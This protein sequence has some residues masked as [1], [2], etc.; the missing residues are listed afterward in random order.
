M[1]HSNSTN[2]VATA[3]MATPPRAVR[4]T[5]DQN[6]DDWNAYYQLL[7]AGQLSQYGGEFVVVRDGIVVTHGADP[8]FVRASAAKQLG[9]AADRL[10]VPFVDDK[11][12]IAAE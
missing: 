9:V 10:V 3:N 12:C 11:E 8:D 4:P 6:L 7:L 5:A 1:P 2:G